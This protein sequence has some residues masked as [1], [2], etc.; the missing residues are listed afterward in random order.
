MSRSRVSGTSRAAGTGSILA[1]DIP[2]KGPRGKLKAR[3]VID[4]KLTAPS[5]FAI[6]SDGDLYVAE[7]FDQR[8]R[9]FSA[10]GKK[11]GM[12][13]EG[14]RTCRSSWCMCRI[15]RQSPRLGARDYAGAVAV[16]LP[17]RVPAS[18]TSKRTLG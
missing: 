10:T 11:K 9:R 5:G 14:S 16:G 2:A 12:F 3:T 13:I 18:N 15:E 8:V 7:R 6:G 17:G 1:F 4:G